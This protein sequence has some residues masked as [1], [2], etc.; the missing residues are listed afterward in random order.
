MF[1]QRSILRH[2][3]WRSG[4]LMALLRF[5][6]GRCRVDRVNCFRSA[7]VII[8][9]AMSRMAVATTAGAS[10]D[11]VPTITLTD[12]QLS[13]TL[14][15]YAQVLEDPTGDLSLTQVTDRHYD[16]LFRRST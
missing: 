11:N 2:F 15:L 10:P 3:S 4:W 8:F 13:Y 9:F 1:Y 14:G 7:L 5:R 16:S 6:P 12:S